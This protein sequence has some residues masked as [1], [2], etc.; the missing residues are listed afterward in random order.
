VQD[1][2]VENAGSG[3]SVVSNGIVFKTEP[4][5]EVHAPEKCDC[6]TGSDSTLGNFV[7]LGS[8]SASRTYIFGGLDAAN[9]PSEASAKAVCGKTTDKFILQ[10]KENGKFVD[11]KT[12]WRLLNTI[13]VSTNT[14]VGKQIED[15]NNKG[16]NP[17]N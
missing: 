17:D 1:Y 11:P 7:S 12:V 3:V 13:G 9:A 6:S 16:I 2:G 14:T 4:G 5:I 15:I 8:M 10:V